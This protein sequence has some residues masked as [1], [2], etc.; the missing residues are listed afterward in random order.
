MLGYIRDLLELEDNTSTLIA[1]IELQHARLL[2][3]SVER[4]GLMN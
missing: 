2:R 1:Q 4:G 3:E